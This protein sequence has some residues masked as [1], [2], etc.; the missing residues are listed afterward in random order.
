[1]ARNRRRSVEQV[2]RDNR[3]VEL[4]RRNLNYRQ[5]ANELGFSSVSSAYEAV[6]RGL[7]DSVA[8][9]NDEVRRQELDRLDD[10]AR[11][12]LRVLARTHYVLSQGKAAA[13]PETG[14]LLV[15][16]GPTLAAIGQLLKIMERRAKYLGLDAPAKVE[17]LSLDAVDE[18][19]RKLSAELGVQVPD[20][21]E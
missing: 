12:A 20:L 16:D 2:D 18:E 13:H 10:L 11:A 6:Q 14:E 1:M 9:T 19:I 8:E 17:L 15:D 5:I 3:A 4:R 7:A 21:S